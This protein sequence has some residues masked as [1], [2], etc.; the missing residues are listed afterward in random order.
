MQTLMHEVDD[1]TFQKK[2][3]TVN[4]VLKSINA[5]ELAQFNKLN[6]TITNN[7]NRVIS[8]TNSVKKLNNLV[9]NLTYAAMTLVA[10]EKNAYIFIGKS[11]K[12]NTLATQWEQNTGYRYI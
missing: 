5:H 1:G 6:N 11:S 2:L 10:L 3:E 4:L 12:Y 9:N 7:N 8:I